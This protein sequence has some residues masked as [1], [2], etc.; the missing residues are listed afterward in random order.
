MFHVG[1]EIEREGWPNEESW[2]PILGGGG[3]GGGH[4]Y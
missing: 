2:G 3:G 4:E 1:K